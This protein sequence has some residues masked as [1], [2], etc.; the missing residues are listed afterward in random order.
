MPKKQY[1]FY[2]DSSRC[3]GCK[4]CQVA[5]KDK[6]NLGAGI[7]WRR[8]YEAGA[9][10]WARKGDAWVHHVKAY[11]MSIA[12]NHCEK[13]ICVDVCPTKAMKKNKNGIVL[14]DEKKCIG[15][16]YCRWACP[17]GAPQY[18]EKKGIMGKC[19]FCV[20]YLEQRRNPSCVDSC[21]MRALDFGELSEMKK[22]YG[23]ASEIFPLP[24]ARYTQPALIVKPHK[25]A[26]N[27][28]DSSAAIQNKE[29]V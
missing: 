19:D 14:V 27:T 3:S 5:C 10:G 21:P 1:A 24:Q 4:T 20:D 28:N 13:P 16:K 8:V 11:N 15:C 29:E 22:K 26:L 23:D 7:R 6:N 12:C 25:D 9:G 17:Y 2:F 18:D